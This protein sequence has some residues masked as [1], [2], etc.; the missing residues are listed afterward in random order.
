MSSEQAKP[1]VQAFG[2][3]VCFLSEL[4]VS[5]E[6]RLILV[7]EDRYCRCSLQVW[8]RSHEAQRP[9]H[10]RDAARVHENEGY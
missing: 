7:V 8:P 6:Q 2:R 5:G 4:R 3:K 1:S 9:A 10:R